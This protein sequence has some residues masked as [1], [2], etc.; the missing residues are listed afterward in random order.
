MDPD[1]FWQLIERSKAA[2]EGDC[3]RQ[4]DALTMLLLELPATDIMAFDRLFYQYVDQA[5]RNDLWAAAYIIQGGCSDDGF[6]YFLR[7]LIG[8]G[9]AVYTAALRDPESL[10]S[11]V[12]THF[13]D[14][15]FLRFE[16]APFL[17]FECEQ[18]AYVAGHAYE[19]KTGS[20]MPRPAGPTLELIG[21]D[22][23]E[24]DLPAMFPKLW[25]AF[26]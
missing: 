2:S 9:E 20:E 12:T 15:Q 10:L 25:A 18:L 16:G 4:A 14:A 11:V 21:E 13:G 17:R 8:Q 3:A 23:D 7:W 26:E 19:R 5:Y 24:E 1:Q 22:W 6:E